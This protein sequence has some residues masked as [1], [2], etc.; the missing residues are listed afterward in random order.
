[1]IVNDSWWS[2]RSARSTI[3]DYHRLSWAVWPGLKNSKLKL[4]RHVLN[5]NL[6]RA[7]DLYRFHEFSAGQFFCLSLSLIA[8][9]DMIIRILPFFHS[10]ELCWIWVSAAVIWGHVHFLKYTMSCR[11]L[12]FLRCYMVTPCRQA[13]TRSTQLSMVAILGFQFGLYRDVVEFSFLRSISLASLLFYSYKSFL[14][15][16]LVS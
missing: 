9:L 1:M 7:V 2:N 13:P 8:T 14:R 5:T 11:W 4:T 3:I 10:H 16:R 12:R 15:R 6:V